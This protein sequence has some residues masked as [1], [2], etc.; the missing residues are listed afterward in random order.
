M[1][2]I[3]FT[4]KGVEDQF[5]K[6]VQREKRAKD[7]LFPPGQVP[8]V[9]RICLCEDG[10]RGA[11][12]TREVIALRLT[13]L[14]VNRWRLNTRIEIIPFTF[15]DNT[16]ENY[17]LLVNCDMFY[18][19]G[20]FS[21]LPALKNA[22]LVEFLRGR[23]QCNEICYLA[24]CGGALISG[25]SARY[26]TDGLDLLDGVDILYP[27]CGK[28]TAAKVENNANMVQM[29]SG[30]AAF[31]LMT[32]TEQRGKSIFV[33]KN[34]SQWWDFS[35]GNSLALQ[36]FVE[37]KATSWKKY[38]YRAQDGSYRFW[39]FNLCGKL[40]YDEAATD[41]EMSTAAADIQFRQMHWD[42]EFHCSGEHVVYTL[43]C[44][45]YTSDAA[46]E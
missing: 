9:Y 19:A 6:H 43:T 33:V 35:Q 21:Q 44:L 31:I 11:Y 13:D 38:K 39:W 4:P 37:K 15:I 41:E 25:C 24:V 17:E 12:S 7:V 40:S 30:C 16:T 34:Y 14:F 23:V 36:R 18:F 29:T 22:S 1:V 42:K 10:R 27:A 5:V 46:D 28:A 8:A 3:I 26:G 32:P 20:V 45:L 2:R